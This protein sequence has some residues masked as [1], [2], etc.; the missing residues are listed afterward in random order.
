[1]KRLLVQLF[2]L[3]FACSADAQQQNS[4]KLFD[5]TQ[6]IADQCQSMGLKGGTP[7]FVQCVVQLRKVVPFNETMANQVKEKRLQQEAEQ[8]RKDQENEAAMLNEMRRQYEAE[9]QRRDAANAQAQ[10]ALLYELRRQQEMDQLNATARNLLEI[11]RP[12]Q[13]VPTTPMHLPRTT[14]CT[15]RWNP[16]GNVM[17]TTCD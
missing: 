11:G 15:S 3:M 1:M 8:K 9:L 7:E 17:Q 10:A 12:Q 16:I 2:F 6:Y 14:N 13:I 5:K 4:S